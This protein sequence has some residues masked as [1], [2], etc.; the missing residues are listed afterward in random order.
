[1]S[2]SFIRHMNHPLIVLLRRVRSVCVA[3][4]SWIE[5]NRAPE[6]FEAAHVHMKLLRGERLD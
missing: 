3:A 2:G 5:P 6:V 4:K 1:M